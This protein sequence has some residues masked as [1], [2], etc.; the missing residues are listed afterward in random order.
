MKYRIKHKT[1]YRYSQSVAMCVNEARM[2][3]LS[4]AH[5]TCAKNRF[6][7]QPVPATL[8]RRMDYFDNQVVHFDILQAHQELS[9]SVIS[10]VEVFDHSGQGLALAHQ[11]WENVRD[12]VRSSAQPEFIALREYTLASPL[13]PLID[14]VHDYAQATFLPGRPVLEAVQDLMTRIFTEFKY[15]PAATTISTPLKEVMAQRRGV[16]QDFAHLAIACLR[17]VGLPAAYI[18]GYLETTPPPGQPKL[19]G[20]DASHAWFAVHMLDGGWVHFDPTNNIMPREQ[21]IIVAHGRDF[22]DVT[23]LKGVIYG[24]NEHKLRVSVDVQRIDDVSPAT[25]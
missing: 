8:N 24:G 22:A 10:E 19:E 17:S 16:C 11:P 15:D 6:V 14:V 13:I 25:V 3:P 7:I 23:P 4:N 5:Q 20:A 21:H 2:S 12:T 1:V 9:V 18:S